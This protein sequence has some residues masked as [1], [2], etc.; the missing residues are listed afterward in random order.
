M[1]DGKV[2]KVGSFEGWVWGEGGGKSA[3]RMIQWAADLG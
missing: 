3:G 1:V 2:G